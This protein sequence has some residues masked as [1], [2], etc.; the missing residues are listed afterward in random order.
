MPRPAVIKLTSPGRIASDDPRLSRWNTSPSNRYVT[1]ASPIC[2][3][4]RTLMPPP[5]RNSAGPIWSKKMKGP[6]ICVWAAGSARR[7]SKPP[8]SRARVTMTCSIASQD[9]AS[10]GTGS[11]DGCPL[12]GERS[13]ALLPLS[14]GLEVECPAE[15]AGVHAPFFPDPG[16][17]AGQDRDGAGQVFVGGALGAGRHGWHGPRAALT[18][19]APVGRDLQGGATMANVGSIK[20]ALQ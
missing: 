17:S 13:W 20:L 7:T 5:I 3:C 14:A 11:F 19:V 16:S 4:G 1:V 9:R 8:R 12:I 15:G 10:P 6:T 2:G 18:R